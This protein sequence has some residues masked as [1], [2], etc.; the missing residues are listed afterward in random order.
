MAR[1][2]TLRSAAMNTAR[3]EA[4]AEARSAID[5]AR[6]E[7]ALAD[8]SH[9]DG[10]ADLVRRIV[11]RLDESLPGTWWSEVNEDAVVEA[12]SDLVHAHDQAREL[13]WLMR[14]HLRA[15]EVLTSPL[16]E[17][18]QQ[19]RALVDDLATTGAGQ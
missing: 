14:D 3:N 18:Y 15:L 2:D 8:Q 10:R 1:Q 19:L 5:A 16:A 13:R 9:R 12:L 11:A 4:K 7:F 6:T 17:S